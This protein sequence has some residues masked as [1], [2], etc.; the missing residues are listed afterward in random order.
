MP[1]HHNIYSC[2]P[3]TAQDNCSCATPIIYQ[4][5][6][7]HPVHS[8]CLCPCQQGLHISRTS[9]R[10]RTKCKGMAPHRAE[11]PN[12]QQSNPTCRTSTNQQGQKDSCLTVT[13]LGQRQYINCTT[14]VQKARHTAVLVIIQASSSTAI[15]STAYVW[16]HASLHNQEQKRN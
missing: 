3:A 5:M 12:Q 9:A 6:R 8:S 4:G 15:S 10:H 14:A 11:M 2:K 1:Q 7:Q 16:R 13:K